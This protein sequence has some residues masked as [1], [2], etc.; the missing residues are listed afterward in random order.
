VVTDSGGLQ[1]ETFLLG[2][3]CTTLRTETEWP[4]TLADG[5]NVLAPGLDDLGAIVSR[6]VPAGPRGAPYG[7]GHAAEAVAK[8]LFEE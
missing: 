4:E 1:K 3:L 7:D 2:R 6:P 8:A 5:W